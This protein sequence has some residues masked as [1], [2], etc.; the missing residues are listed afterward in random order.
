MLFCSGIRQ[1]VG[2]RFRLATIFSKSRASSASFSECVDI[3]P[4]LFRLVRLCNL[5][6]AR[7]DSCSSLSR[8]DRL[9]LLCDDLAHSVRSSIAVHDFRRSVLSPYMV[10]WWGQM[11]PGFEMV[12][13]GSDG[14]DENSL[15]ED[16]VEAPISPAP[17]KLV[18]WM[19]EFFI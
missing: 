18:F 10:C 17:P 7:S 19:V 6:A 1:T 5:S 16:S 14:H 13:S 8:L 15:F 9:T 3:P 2:A 11:P 12:R 4:V